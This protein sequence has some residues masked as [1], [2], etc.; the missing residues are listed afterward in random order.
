MIDTHGLPMPENAPPPRSCVR[1]QHPEPGLAVLV[2]D[3]PHRTLA[4]LDLPLLRDLDLALDEIEGDASLRGLV[5]TGR[6]PTSFAAGAD[7]DA[8]A[9]LTDPAVV[10]RVVG[11]GQK[12]FERIARL[13]RRSPRLRT[14]AA[15]GGPVPGGAL[16]LALACGCIVAAVARET[17]IGLPETQ[18]GILP[19]WG[20]TTRLPRRAGVPR[21]LEAI[22]SGKLHSAREA[23]SKGIVD[24]LAEP[25]DLLRI[26]GDIAA[27]RS[28]SPRRSR[29]WRALLVDRNPVAAGFIASRAREQVL[30]R[31][32]GHYPAPLAA[33]EIACRAP[34]T[35]TAKSLAAE[36][37]AASAL[38]VS[39]TCKHLIA[40][41]RGSEE[42]KKLGRGPDGRARRVPERAGV[43]GAGVM[44]RGIAGL[45]AERGI[46]T[47]IFD[48]APAALDAALSEHRAAAAERLRKRRSEPR[49]ATEAIDRLDASRELAGFARAGFVIEAVAEKLETKRAVLGQIALQVRADAILATNTSSL[50]VAAIAEGI[51][52]PERVA[53]MHFFNPVKKMPLVEVVRGRRTSPEAVAACAGLAVH[54]GKTPVVVADVAGFLVNRL[55]G[56]YLD[57][58]L[59]M[60]AGG[61]DPARIDA[62]LEDFGMP[63]GPIALLDEVGFDIASH[64]AAS[65]HAA[66]GDRMAPCGVLDPMIRAG[67]LGKKTGRGFYEHA[68]GGRGKKPP[69]A[70]DLARFIPPG[71]PRLPALTH[72]EIAD[73]AV[74]AMLNEAARALEEE[75]AATPREIDLATVFGIGFPPFRGGI[76]SFADSLGVHAVVERMMRIAAAPDVASRP[77]GRERF[78]PSD[79][80]SAMARTLKSFHA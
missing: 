68:P 69:S 2:L 74:L 67:I 54:L 64:A 72:A 63:M 33:L 48:V 3:P 31:T 76:L 37:R 10:A 53:G 60:F 26:A 52:V 5:V 66:Y 34:R 32:H 35:S 24:R 42:A 57:E 18:L 50:S 39:P 47:R 46:W 62:A 40:I 77:G 17:R 70:P 9:A 13:R 59:R 23:L 55:L 15:V 20:G 41:F 22:L 4:V 30:A 51:P 25:E 1:L 14:V 56:P 44:G 28:R 65:L 73:R 16:E 58:S 12:L 80:I 45:L 43:L 27:G 19:A 78:E 36:L 71:R 38:A 8:L 79:S 6:S 11:V 49:E 61:V 75:V 29:G 21:A 7:L